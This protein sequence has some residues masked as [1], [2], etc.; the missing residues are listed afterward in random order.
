M[1]KFVG[2]ALTAMAVAAAGTGCTRE[3]ADDA[4][5]SPAQSAPAPAGVDAGALDPANY[6]TKPLPPMGNGGGRQHAA[7]LEANRLADAVV[8]PWEVDEAINQIAGL[9]FAYGGSPILPERLQVVMDKRAAEVGQPKMVTGYASNRKLDNQRMLNNVVLEMQDPQAASAAAHDMPQ[10]L[11]DLAGQYE[12][13]T[14]T[15]IVPIPGH[16]DAFAVASTAE[17]PETGDRPW[18]MVESFTAHGPFVLFQRAQTTADMADAVSLVARTLDL[19]IPAIAGFT[20]TAAADLPNLPKD[21]SGLLARTLPVGPKGET[22]VNNA[23]LG[24][25]AM[26]HEEPNPIAAHKAYS[27]AGAD[28]KVVADGTVFRTRDAAAAKALA[29]RFSETETGPHAPA[30]A[31]PNLPD[32]TCYHLTDNDKFACAGASDQHTFVVYGPRLQDVHHMAAA[33]YLLLA[34]K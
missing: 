18:N 12:S 10:R 8:G 32:S 17:L 26:L 21:P 4:Q 6:P 11:L 29:T 22:F 3:A 24:T 13:T 25:R 2:A 5:A 34:A 20:P 28:L 19:Q 23:T 33:Q 16:D 27:D 31:V 9:G 15:A 30:D 7:V 14:G 1:I